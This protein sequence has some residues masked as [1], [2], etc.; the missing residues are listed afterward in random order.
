MSQ[1]IVIL[2]GLIT[3]TLFSLPSHKVE[4]A[5]RQISLKNKVRFTIGSLTEE[6]NFSKLADTDER[7]VDADLAKFKI[8]RVSSVF[9]S[10]NGQYI[11]TFAKD[12]EN[13]IKRVIF[14][15]AD[16]KSYNFADDVVEI[17]NVEIKTSKGSVSVGEGALISD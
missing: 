5:L 4:N 12:S 17:K 3:L 2:I 16:G 8:V 13:K 9:M 11:M 14:V 15:Y 1:Y 7:K 6:A 10:T